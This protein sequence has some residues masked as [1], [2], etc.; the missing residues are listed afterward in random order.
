M[1][2]AGV[3][4][5]F[6]QFYPAVHKSLEFTACRVLNY[7][8]PGFIGLA[9]RYRVSMA[10]PSS[11]A[12]VLR[13]AFPSHEA[14]PSRPALLWR[15]PHRPPGKPSQSFGHRANADEPNALFAHEPSDATL[16]HGLRV[17]I[18]RVALHGQ[19]GLALATETSKGVA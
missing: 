3:R 15:G 1:D 2:M 19:S 16:I 13:R 9:E 10:W 12:R 4:V 14:R 6:C 11:L 8:G 7:L 5:F 17:P 18:N